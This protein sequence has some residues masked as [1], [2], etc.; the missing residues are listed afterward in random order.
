VTE[1]LEEALEPHSCPT[2]LSSIVQSGLRC[3]CDCDASCEMS[4][5]KIGSSVVSSSADLSTSATLIGS[6]HCVNESQDYPWSEDGC[7][8]LATCGV[9]QRSC[10]WW[11]VAAN[12]F[13]ATVTRL[14]SYVP[15]YGEAYIFKPFR[16]CK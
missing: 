2:L 3:C 14:E 16:S 10:P 5:C 13:W 4:A 6:F 7:D 11:M 9:D 1:H 12:R 15:L 8:E